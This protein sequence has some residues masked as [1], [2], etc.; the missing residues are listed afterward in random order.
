MERKFKVLKSFIFAE[1]I[2]SKTVKLN[3]DMIINEEYLGSTINFLLSDGYIEEILPNENAI[4]S[5]ETETGSMLDYDRK[6]NIH[7]AMN[8]LKNNDLK[9]VDNSFH[10]CEW[11]YCEDGELINKENCWLHELYK[12]EEILNMT[13]T[14]VKPKEEKVEKW[15][16]ITSRTQLFKMIR[17]GKRIR[18]IKSIDANKSQAREYDSTKLMDDIWNIFGKFGVNGYHVEYLED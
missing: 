18:E 8:L 1:S 4:L 11:M 2:Y 7:E 17:D 15:V 9:M 14:L 13:F 12:L 6:Y 16:E 5:G 3:K 10:N